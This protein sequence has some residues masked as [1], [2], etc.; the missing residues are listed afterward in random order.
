M[1]SGLYVNSS[2]Q[3]ASAACKRFGEPDEGD[4]LEFSKIK[5]KGIVEEYIDKFEEL[6]TE[7]MCHMPQATSHKT[8][9]YF[10]VCRSTKGGT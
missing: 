7:V 1:A 2:E 4:L 5:Q 3:M 10:S 8:I 9:L 6:R